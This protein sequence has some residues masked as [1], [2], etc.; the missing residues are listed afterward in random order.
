MLQKPTSL[1]RECSESFSIVPTGVPYFNHAGIFDELAQQ[2]VEI[3]AVERSILE[4]HGK[5]D[6]QRAQPSFAGNGVQAFA[7]AEFVFVCRADGCG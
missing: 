6:Q 5:L 7:S 1:L 2:P 3:F 4:R